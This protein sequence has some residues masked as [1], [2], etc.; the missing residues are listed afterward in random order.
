M[1]KVVV[2][3]PWMGANSGANKSALYAGLSRLFD[4]EF[5]AVELPARLEALNYV[6]SFHP[7]IKRWKARKSRLDEVMRKY[8]S[9]FRLTTDLF[10]SALASRS[11]GCDA[12]LQM[13]SLFGPVENKRGVPYFSYH[14]SSVAG[15]ETLWRQW[16]PDDFA[17][18]R[19]E[20]FGLE[21]NMFRSMTAVMTYS[22]FARDVIEERYGV[23]PGRLKVVGSALKIAE[24]HV[25]DWPGR[26]H[27][28]LFVTTDFERK[29]G[30][31]AISIF[32]KVAEL[33]PGATLTIV[34]NVPQGVRDA[35][36]PW[37]DLRGPLG[38]SELIEVYLRSSL[39]IHPAKYDPFPSVILEA[40]NFEVPSVASQVCAIPEIIKDSV[41]GLLAEPSDAALFAGKVAGLLLD[42]PRLISMGR[43]AKADVTE[44]FHPDVVAANIGSVIGGCL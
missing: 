37:L 38:R 22:A 42:R 33:V 15:L 13:S 19:D 31:E 18:F 30:F 12:I 21:G 8:P 27:S 17:K 23:E 1:K 39:M 41:T 9:T 43:A 2:L 29:G 3:D 28:V 34:G 10:N 11:S 26:G 32:A 4:L 6:K 14:D 36:K 7:D 44:R 20:W 40:A 16:L 5:V 35:K 25:I 24:D